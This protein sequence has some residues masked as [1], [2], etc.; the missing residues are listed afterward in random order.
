MRRRHFGFQ[1]R[2]LARAQ[3]PQV[4]HAIAGRGLGDGCK[5]GLLSGM[6]HDQLANSLVRHAM[7]GAEI[8]EQRLA[9]DAKPR[10]QRALRIIDAGMDHLAVAGAGLHAD[11]IVLFQD[12][13][14]VP[15]KVQARAPPPAP[16]HPRR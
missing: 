14:V 4:I 7:S 15:G 2:N 12:D 9:A 10:L 6:A 1:R 11:M 5:L 13:G 3:R 16:P 8:I